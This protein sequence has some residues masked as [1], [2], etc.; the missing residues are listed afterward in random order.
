MPKPLMRFIVAAPALALIACTHRVPVPM[1]RGADPAVVALQA[2]DL[3]RN[4]RAHVVVLDSMLEWHVKALTSQDAVLHVE[5]LPSERLPPVLGTVRVVP[6][7]RRRDVVG[8]DSAAAFLTRDST[9]LDHGRSLRF[10]VSV[11]PFDTYGFIAV[12]I[13]TQRGEQWEV[14]QV[15]YLDA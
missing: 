2:V 10:T 13:V 3:T 9:T 15:D 14:L 4:S 7:G 5:R 8:P 6:S 12:V 1:S 11:A